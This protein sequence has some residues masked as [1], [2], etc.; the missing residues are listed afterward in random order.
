MGAQPA[1][2]VPTVVLGGEASLISDKIAAH[3]L[4]HG[5]S[6]I[7]HHD[8]YKA[9][10]APLPDAARVL[11]LMTDMVGHSLSTPMVAEARSRGIKVVYGCRKYAVFASR[12]DAAGFPVRAPEAPAPLPVAPTVAATLTTLPEPPEPTED[13]PMPEATT[14]TNHE[15]EEQVARLLAQ[16]PTLSNRALVR[17]YPRITYTRLDA[18]ARAARQALGISPQSRYVV[19]MRE[20]F[21]AA[22]A[23]RGIASS[24]SIPE[25][26]IMRREAVK[27]A[28][29]ARGVPKADLRD[30]REGTLLKKVLVYLSR[31]PLATNTDLASVFSEQAGSIP[32]YATKGRKLLGLSTG[33]GRAMSAQVDATKW[34]ATCRRYGL[35]DTYPVPPSGVLVRGLREHRPSV[36]PK[37]QKPVAATVPAPEAS[38]ADPLKDVRDLV[39]LLR[40]EM[41]KHRIESLTL[42]AHET[43]VQRLVTIT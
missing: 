14:S 28:K 43:K 34:E 31:H 41:G 38:A 36:A 13:V 42:T 33:R 10:S 3:L 8:W 19:I 25:S 9:R 5:L 39:E 16:D 30:I 35:T 22:C 24:V 26:G 23:E 12:L 4:E 6:V 29:V 7:A 21:L 1:G 20:T 11:F 32:G 27:P 15:L 17:L 40:A 2:L 18:A 37:P